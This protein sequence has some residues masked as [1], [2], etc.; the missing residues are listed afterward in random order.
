MACI[1]LAIHF[2][3]LSRVKLPYPVPQIKWSLKHHE[4]YQSP[5]FNDRSWANTVPIPFADQ[6]WLR[7]HFKLDSY[8]IN[9]IRIELQGAYDVYLNGVFIGSNGK[10]GSSRETEVAGNRIFYIQLPEKIRQEN[11]VLSLN[12]SSFHNQ[13]NQYPVLSIGNYESLIKS[14]ISNAA[15]MNIFAGIFLIISVYFFL[16]YFFTFRHIYYLYFSGISIL[17]F[18]L[19]LLDYSGPL[20]TYDYIFHQNRIIGLSLL[21]SGIC[22]L[23]PFFFRSFF[24]VRFPYLFIYAS[25]VIMIALFVSPSSR[26]YNKTIGL[27]SFILSLLIVYKSLLENREYSQLYF[28]IVSSLFFFIN[29]NY[30]VSIHFGF[31]AL[32]IF[33]LVNLLHFQNKQKKKHHETEIRSIRLETELLKKNIQPHFLLNSL[34]SLMELIETAPEKSIRFIEALAA[35]FK[36][37]NSVSSKKMICL[38]EEIQLCQR[39]LVIMSYRKE[40]PIKL[41]INDYDHTIEIPPGIILTL[42]EN[43]ITHNRVTEKNNEIRIQVMEYN[44]ALTIEVRT[45]TDAP[46]HDATGTGTGTKYITA[47]LEESFPNKWHFSHTYEDGSWVT[48]IKIKQL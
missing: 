21:T 45:L 33:V 12:I 26:D 37:L 2:Y 48:L 30:A 18:L 44:Q 40:C 7:Y 34:T 41:L 6:W 27:M 8:L 16:L 19:I 10:P 20:F 36:I 25:I 14:S 46:D 38:S 23:I 15:F 4:S 24:S 28:Y 5:D 32:I 35:E 11:N 39:H 42:V 3:N 17:F 1:V 43:W 9:T 29:P 31:A 22:T 47:R 13:L